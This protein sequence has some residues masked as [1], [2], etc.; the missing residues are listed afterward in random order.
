MDMLSKNRTLL[1]ILTAAAESIPQGW[2]VI[3]GSLYQTVWNLQHGREPDQDIGDYDVVYFD[4][5]TT[6]EQ[7]QD[8]EQR[9]TAS[10]PGAKIEVKN[11]AFI[12]NAWYEHQYGCPK[13]T[14]G[15]LSL[16]D[17]IA[18]AYVS[19]PVI[20]VSW[21]GAEMHVLELTGLDDLMGLRVYP[22]FTFRDRRVLPFY[23]NKFRKWYGTWPL[24][25]FHNW[26]GIVVTSESEIR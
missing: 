21:T 14:S 24:V 7:E 20:G 13:D 10:V 6:K 5:S 4:P 2:Y 12:T 9:I 23:R 3:G 16:E 22:N 25:K 15:Y 11:Q 1:A 19:S 26:D 18:K 17:A 8:Y